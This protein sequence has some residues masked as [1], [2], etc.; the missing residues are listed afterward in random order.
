MSDLFRLFINSASKS[1]QELQKEIQRVIRKKIEN[2]VEEAIRDIKTDGE[3][4]PPRENTY[5]DKRQSRTTLTEDELAYPPPETSYD[6]AAITEKIREMRKLGQTFYH[7]Y[8]MRQCAE[9]S[10]IK[11]GEFMVDVTDDFNRSVYCGTE[12][13]IY[14]ALSLEQLRTYFTWRTDVRR[15]VYNKTDKSYVIL[16]CYELLNK[17]GVLSSQDAF[18]RLI[19]VW[20]NCREFCPYL[21]EIMPVWLKDFYAFNSID[22]DFSQY[23]ACFPVKPEP[24]DSAT[25]ELFDGNYS[26][27]LE[28]LAG[29]SSYNLRGSI[30]YTEENIPL[31]Q[32]A[33][34]AALIALDD[35][36]KQRG[37]SLFEL[38]CGKTRKDHNWEPFY[39]AF[40]DRDRMDG[41][42]TCRISAAER[43]CI[44]RGQPSHEKF[45]SAPYRSFIGYILKSVESVLR[46]RTGFR[47]SIVPNLSIVLD[48]FTNREKLFA[49]ASE[50]EFA[51]LIPDTVNAWCDKNNIF[52]PPKEK[53]RKK[54]SDAANDVSPTYTAADAPPQKIDIDIES[55][56]QIRKA[57]EETARKLII[58]E[59]ED[60]IP[61]QDIEDITARIV[62]EVFDSQAAQA[63]VEAHSQYDFSALSD[64]WR[65]LAEALDTQALELL[66]AFSSGNAQALC[67]DRG[68]L[69]ETA[70]DEINALALENIGDCLIENGELIPDY[71][72]DVDSI[73][74]LMR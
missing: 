34:E 18:D 25:A 44:K 33:T 12:R 46:E 43:Y 7:G 30:F 5:Y 49:A 15:G 13:P 26:N 50:A 23:E 58:E 19:T 32:A 20:E 3:K 17:I 69:P 9:V 52:P 8:M 71:A 73:V 35:Y 45:E 68:I 59:Y 29:C 16:Y 62:D 60:S 2:V 42:R 61:E 4:I 54:R 56:E 40:V 38:I 70:F 53:K 11:Q 72:E 64:G 10:I 55:L 6:S 28:Y 74:M 36:F 1:K 37:I 31:L 57:A 24:S 27:K 47:Y 67:R 48:D 51:T 21:D 14:G 22:G 65:Q 41:F 63:G 39:A 66:A